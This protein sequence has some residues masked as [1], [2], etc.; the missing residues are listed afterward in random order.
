MA[1]RSSCDLA[2]HAVS[3]L[4]KHLRPALFLA[5][6]IAAAVAAAPA[7]PRGANDVKPTLP[8]E[9]L[10]ET[11]VRPV[12]VSA[13]E[14]CHGGSKQMGGLRIDS[15][16]ALLQGGGRG[17]SIVP[18]APEHSL[19]LRA[20]SHAPGVPAMPPA[21][22]LRPDQ[23]AA[24]AEWIRAGAPWPEAGS[25]TGSPSLALWSL[26][27][28]Q[29]PPVPP[30]RNPPLRAVRG[31][32]QSAPTGGPWR[33]A[34]RNPIDAFI[35][36]RL[37]AKGMSPA[38]PAARRELIRRLYSTSAS[39]T[40]CSIHRAMESGGR[41]TGSTWSAMPTATATSETPRRRIPGSTGTT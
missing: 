18:G 24:L 13:C 29:R 31:G 27:P 19:L 20:V 15:R 5:L 10:F 30:I 7:S 36:A 38:P 32:P 6:L 33:T 2:S 16:A 9:E 11:K 39:S 12:L 26:K 8:T 40:S 17:P 1:R 41:D 22:R 4:P 37:E 35:L 23:I 14:K 25:K 34:I 28:V 3:M 21:S